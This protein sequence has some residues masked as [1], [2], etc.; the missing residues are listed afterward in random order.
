MILDDA[1]SKLLWDVYNIKCFIRMVKA[2][3]E[4]SEKVCKE[5]REQIRNQSREVTDE[6]VYQRAC[7]KLDK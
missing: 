1:K 5:Q 3:K 7:D 6:E 2:A 4:R